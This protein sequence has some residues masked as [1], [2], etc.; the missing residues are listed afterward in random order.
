MAQAAYRSIMSTPAYREL[1][2]RVEL[3]DTVEEV[4]TSPPLAPEAAL[5]QPDKDWFAASG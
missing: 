1:P 4:D 2:P 5:P 3:A